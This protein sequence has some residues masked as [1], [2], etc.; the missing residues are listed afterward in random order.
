[1]LKFEENWPQKCISSLCFIGRTL[2]CRIESHVLF[3]SEQNK[4]SRALDNSC[5]QKK[6]LIQNILAVS[7]L[8]GR[9]SV[10]LSCTKFISMAFTCHVNSERS[11][12]PFNKNLAVDWPY[13]LP[14]PL[15]LLFYVA[16]WTPEQ[17]FYVFGLFGHMQ[18]FPF[19][20]FGVS[21]SLPGEEE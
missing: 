9:R 13:G 17:K 19:M 10:K 2:K 20:F 5:L 4:G 3:G 8:P 15:V 21:L 16:S 6:K 18:C 12:R 14:F 11:M 7:Y 1:M